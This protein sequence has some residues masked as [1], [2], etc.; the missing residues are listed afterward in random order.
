M[1]CATAKSFFSPYLDGAITG[2]EMRALSQH[3]EACAD[4]R[5]SYVS[6]R[7]TQQLLYKMGCRK[8]PT[9]LALKLR[10]AISQ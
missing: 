10:V 5:H 4:C 9:D 3:L 1:K 7:Q 2:K 8:P 6:L